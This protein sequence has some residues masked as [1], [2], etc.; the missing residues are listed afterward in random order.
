[1]RQKISSGVKIPAHTFLTKENNVERSAVFI[2]RDGTINEQMGYVNHISRFV[3][4]PMT[5]EAIKLLNEQHY[6]VI[7]VSNQSGVARGYFPIDLVNEVHETMQR[8]L[9]EMGALID[10]I[11]FCPHLPQGEIKEYGIRC[12]CRKPMTGMI[13][14]ARKSFDIDMESSYVIGDH[15]TDIEFARR[16]GLKGILVRTGYGRGQEKYTLPKKS[17]KPIHIADDLLDGVRWIIEKNVT[18]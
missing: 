16:A 8:S 18:L 17:F 14:Q 13:D 9:M 6:L 10:S 7:V 15:Y 2:D 3:L 11:F 12:D 5:A 1:L 4:L